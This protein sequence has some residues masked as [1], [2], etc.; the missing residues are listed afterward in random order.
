MSCDADRASIKYTKDLVLHPHLKVLESRLDLESL[1]NVLDVGS[2]RG[3]FLKEIIKLNPSVKVTAVE[4]DPDLMKEYNT[5]PQVCAFNQRL[6][7]ASLEPE[8]YDL[9][10]CAHTLEHFSS[11]SLMLL[12]LWDAV[13]PGGLLF[14]AV[15]NTLILSEDT[16]EEFFIDTHTFHFHAGVLETFFR[17]HG[18]E[19]VYSSASPE[20]F[21]LDYLLRKHS[22]SVT[23]STQSLF[24]KPNVE[25]SIGF[26]HAYKSTLIRNRK[27]L[28]T[29]SA[30]INSL[31][32]ENKIVFWGAG[33]I[34]DGLVK[35]GGLDTGKI[36]LLVDKYLFRYMAEVHGVEINPPEA[37]FAYP[38]DT[39]IIIASREYESEITKEAREMGF[40]N[41]CG[42]S[43]FMA[44]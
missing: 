33:R 11:A 34:F 9:I 43:E 35:L 32:G 25:K 28:E 12:K 2:N 3:A 30:K 15:P 22:R 8:R 7:S 10:Y 24:S 5:H 14:I 29:A 13:K 23:H 6:E 36:Q 17:F 41:I 19:I 18:L 31:P 38:S 27:R 1:Q 4:T 20:S 37:L 26:L 21:E 44:A 16:F 42:Y 40:F 39:I